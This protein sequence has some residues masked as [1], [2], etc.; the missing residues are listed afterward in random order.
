MTPTQ[1]LIATQAQRLIPEVSDLY[2]RALKLERDHGAELQQVDVAYR[3]SARN[4]LHY[5]AVRQ[6][7]IRRLQIVLAALG[8]SSLGRMEAHTL[9]TLHAVLFA[10]H[11][12]A[13]QNWAPDT[14]PPV[15]FHAGQM[16]L[17]RHAEIL[18]GVPAG[19]RSVRIM[20]TMPT[21]AATN[22][23]LI[24]D[25]LAAGMDVMRINCAHDGPE[26]WGAMVSNLRRAQRELG[27]ECKIQ[28]DLGGPKLRTGAIQPAGRILR[29]KPKRDVRGQV[30]I[31][32]RV[33]MTPAETP[34]PAPDGTA[35]TLHV[36]REFLQKSSPGDAVRFLDTRG[37]KR[38]ARITA[39]A[40]ESRLAELT[41][42][43]YVEAGLPVSLY[44]RKE[45][46]GEAKFGHVPDVTEPLHLAEGDLLHLT[47]SDEPGRPAVCDFN[48][49]LIKPVC[50]PC[51]LKEAFDA[52]KPGERIWFDDGKI[53]GMVTGND[54]KIIQ[55][56]I[57]HTGVNG[58]RL[59]PEKGINLPDTDLQVSALTA[60]DLEDLRAV[61]PYA[62][63][64][65]FSFVRTPADVH[66]LHRHLGRLGAKHIGVILKIE[67]GQ[68]FENLPQLLLASLCAPPV[69]VM[70]AR[71]DLGVEVGFERLAEV[72]EEILWLCEAAHVPVIWATQVLEVMAKKGAPSRAEVSDAAMSGR[73]E[74]VMLN[75]GP[76]IVETVLFLNGILERMDAHQ[77]KR[78]TMMRRLSISDLG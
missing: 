20:V 31:P 50:V 42:T 74:C 57:T 67:T 28:A 34:L 77:S 38:V 33:W 51:T 24:R 1:H 63:L 54:G 12:I 59:R 40:G 25:L 70:V 47:R 44:R 55:V 37:K 65:G 30:V 62:D 49:Q 6:V 9:S 60:K 5:L 43:A 75:K 78:R 36:P 21:E 13:N 3:D 64:I 19:K 68:A 66:S 69:G 15:N 10:L 22:P 45:L 32:G 39:A 14:K 35:D 18:L 46:L 58:G 72:Q 48:G 53:G 4:L 29:I 26:T 8:L 73:A 16:L 17:A 27:R 56:E 71:G 23:A 11:R 61:V 2:E 76:Y 41:K 52:V 7:D